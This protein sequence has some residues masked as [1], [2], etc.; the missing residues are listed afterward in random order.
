[1]INLYSVRD[2]KGIYM[3]TFPMPNDEVAKRTFQDALQDKKT[4][5]A[6]HP[7]DMELYRVGTWESKTGEL[8]GIKPEYLASGSDFV[9]DTKKFNELDEETLKKVLAELEKI[10]A[11]Q[12][13]ERLAFVEIKS[14]VTNIQEQATKTENN[15][16]Y[17]DSIA[18]KK[19]R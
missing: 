4:I 1:M 12:E 18:K 13:R 2:T 5:I 15:L 16:K 14:K 10:T 19:K 8:T 7:R 9:N 17:L 3:D 6:Q 11:E